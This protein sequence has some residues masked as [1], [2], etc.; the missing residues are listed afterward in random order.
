MR[1]QLTVCMIVVVTMTGCA[2]MADFAKGMAVESKLW[3]EEVT[4][5]VE[6]RLD[7]D[8]DGVDDTVERVE[9]FEGKL[10]EAVEDVSE[11]IPFGKVAFGALSAILS[12]LG[13]T[14]GT[15][16]YREKIKNPAA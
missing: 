6:R 1:F 13:I 16:F 14:K 8:G 12:I 2:T 15:R 9:E 7:T 5:T 11:T 4:S 10:G 3:K